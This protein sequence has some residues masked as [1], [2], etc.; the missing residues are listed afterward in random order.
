[1]KTYISVNELAE[2]L[3]LSPWSVRH[4]ASK[5]EIP[6]LKIRRKWRFDPDRVQRKLEKQTTI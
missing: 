1:M 5:G 3:N 4:M 6:A 2:R